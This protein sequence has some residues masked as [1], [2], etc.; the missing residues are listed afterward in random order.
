[1]SE[2]I[3][4]SGSITL[5]IAVLGAVLGIINTWRNINKDKVRLKVTPKYAI[6]NNDIEDQLSIEV[7]NFSSFPLI[8]REV[9]V[10]Y[11]GTSKRAAVATPNIYD[12]GSFPRKLEQRISM[13][14]YLPIEI[15]KQRNNHRVKCV[16]VMTDC[17][18]IIKG[19]SSAL[20]E[21]IKKAES[22]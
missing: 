22:I 8:V 11:Y 6:F 10:Y 21:M 15:L 14:V 9:G 1:V 2:S 12:G 13:S 7:I 20:T 4:I 5:A 19:K 18:K 16:Y 3:S 17:G